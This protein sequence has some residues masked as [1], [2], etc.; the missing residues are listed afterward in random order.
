MQ[1]RATNGDGHAN[2]HSTG[3]RSYTDR[4]GQ[5]GGQIRLETIWISKGLD[6]PASRGHPTRTPAQTVMESSPLTQ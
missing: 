1:S 3:G 5:V 2:F 4:G 6:V